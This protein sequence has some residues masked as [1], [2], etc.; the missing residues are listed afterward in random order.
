[1]K[2]FDSFDVE[3]DIL[4]LRATGIDAT[5]ISVKFNN[6]G[7]ITK[8]LFGPNGNKDWIVLDNNDSVCNEEEEKAK[9]LKIQNGQIIHSKC[10]IRVGNYPGYLY[11]L[12]YLFSI[13]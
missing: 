10:I 9:F 3:N 11:I 5:S 2:C 4:Q 13:S 6:N 12:F 7:T 8:F 1:M